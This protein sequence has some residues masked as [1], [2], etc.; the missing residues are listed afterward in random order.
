MTDGWGNRI[1]GR[2]FQSEAVRGKKLKRYLT[3]LA[4]GTETISGC[5]QRANGV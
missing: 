5:E 4:L 1:A 3:V 2:E